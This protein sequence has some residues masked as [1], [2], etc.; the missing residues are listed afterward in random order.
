MP[1]IVHDI[2]S[3]LVAILTGHSVMGRLAER[4]RLPFNGFCRECRSSEKEETVI[5]FF[6]QCPSL[7]S[8]RSEVSNTYS[9]RWVDLSHTCNF[10]YL[11]AF[12]FVLIL[13]RF[14]LLKT[15][16]YK[17]VNANQSR[18]KYVFQFH[19]YNNNYNYNSLSDNFSLFSLQP[20]RKR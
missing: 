12:I 3:T 7:A 6:Y 13:L 18:N 11:Y 14:Y 20:L 19:L 17:F 9:K 4:M 5:H 16:I 10:W 2:I 8:C 15:F 1:L